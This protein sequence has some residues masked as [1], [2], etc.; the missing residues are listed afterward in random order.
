[1]AK[2]CPPHRWGILDLIRLMSAKDNYLARL[3]FPSS[4]DHTEKT[5]NFEAIIQNTFYMSVMHS[6]LKTFFQCV[7]AADAVFC[8][9]TE[10]R[11]LQD[12][13]K[14]AKQTFEE[15]MRY[16]PGSVFHDSLYEYG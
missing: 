6:C 16:I 2:D 4:Q 9:N 3:E 7:F 13:Q 10:P 15:M 12:K 1:M 11:S 14:R 8:E 5:L